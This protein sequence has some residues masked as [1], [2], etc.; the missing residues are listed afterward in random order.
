MVIQEARGEQVCATIADAICRTTL[1]EGT[2]R[3]RATREADDEQDFDE[4]SKSMEESADQE[5]RNALDL[6]K[7]VLGEK[8][9]KMIRP[10][11][12]VTMS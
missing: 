3:S 11:L 1:W 9:A 7:K 2:R 6:L 5:K 10:D 4:A 12:I 8:P